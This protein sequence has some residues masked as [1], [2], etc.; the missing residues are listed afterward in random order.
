MRM[1]RIVSGRHLVALLMV[2]PALAGACVVVTGEG[3]ALRSV[4]CCVA[5][6]EGSL[7]DAL[8]NSDLDSAMMHLR[9]GQDPN[10]AVEFR[11]AILTGDRPL[12]IAPLAIAVASDKEDSVMMLLSAGATLGPRGT[13][14]ARCL[15]ARLGH[16]KIGQL[17]ERYAGPSE[18]DVPCPHHDAAMLA[19][20]LLWFASAAP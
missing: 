4:W 11:H 5:V 19:A 1:N 14:L 12:R 15:S 8:M 6:P 9:G 2:L 17:L 18:P 16:E 3:M 20:P 7:A 10:A 13:A